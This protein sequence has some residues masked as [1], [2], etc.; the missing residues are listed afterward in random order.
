MFRIETPERRE[1][2]RETP[3]TYTS[4]PTRQLASKGK[5]ATVR[6]FFRLPHVALGGAVGRYQRYGSTEPR[7]HLDLLGMRGSSPSNTDGPW[8]PPS[9]ALQ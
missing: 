5:A 3:Y 2:R 8:P 1:S 9:Q 4:P 6:L 7:S